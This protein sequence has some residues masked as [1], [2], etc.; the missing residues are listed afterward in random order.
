MLNLFYET[1]N[2]NVFD[3][4]S[5]INAVEMSA[6]TDVSSKC[7]IKLRINM[8]VMLIQLMKFINLSFLFTL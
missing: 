4:D 7:F 1:E 2:Q 8:Y 3:A 5:I 6:H